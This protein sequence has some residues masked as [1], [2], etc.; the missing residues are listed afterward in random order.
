M[1]K[2]KL[3]NMSLFENI[4]HGSV[5]TDL[6]KPRPFFLGNKNNL[7]QIM[8]FVD[9]D[10]LYLAEILFQHSNLDF[11]GETIK[12]IGVYPHSVPMECYKIFDQNTG[13]YLYIE[14]AFDPNVADYD[15]SDV[16]NA[17]KQLGNDSS[18]LAGSIN[19][20]AVTSIRNPADDYWTN[21]YGYENFSAATGGG[22]DKSITFYKFASTDY[23][24]NTIYHEGGHCFEGL[25]YDVSSTFEWRNA[26][27]QDG[28]FV[29]N[30][31]ASAYQAYVNSGDD[32][33]SYC[34]DFAESI[35]YIGQYG[36]EEF[37]KKFPNRAALIKQIIPDLAD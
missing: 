36:Y 9:D 32:K 31:A 29:T 2:N 20:I 5:S 23:I 28:F 7:V 26:A 22:V 4:A 19:E 13:I 30:Y 24:K 3:I 8:N 12:T 6:K 17:L 25:D 34:E 27:Y 10:D 21:F 35:G 37:E 11:L 33:K 1:D 14:K 16:V 18:A 15:V